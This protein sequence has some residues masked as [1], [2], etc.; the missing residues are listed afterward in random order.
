MAFTGCSASCISPSFP[1]CNG[2][3]PP[4]PP[5]LPAHSRGTPSPK[6]H[7][8]PASRSLSPRSL[9]P[10]TPLPRRQRGPAGV[11][12]HP[13]AL[14]PPRELKTSPG[15]PWATGELCCFWGS[16][17]QPSWAALSTGGGVCSG[18]CTPAGLGAG[19]SLPPCTDK[20]WMVLPHRLP[21]ASHPEG[22][23][24]AGPFLLP[25]ECWRQDWGEKELFYQQC[26]P[27]GARG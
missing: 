25:A 20:R 8:V 16:P 23:D 14:L 18:V 3:D 7:V 1:P 22:A 11:A 4:S 13:T 5:S 17:P 15:S 19:C 26:F 12:L 27:A 24:T 2:R 6:L 21:A 9:S 10:A